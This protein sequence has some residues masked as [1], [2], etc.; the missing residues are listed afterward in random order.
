VKPVLAL[1]THNHVL[2]LALAGALTVQATSLRF[3][4]DLSLAF[5]GLSFLR[6]ER[7]ILVNLLS[8]QETAQ[9]KHSLLGLGGTKPAVQLIN[10]I[11]EGVFDFFYH[12]NFLRHI[13]VFRV[14]SK[15]QG[16][17]PCRISRCHKIQRLS[18]ALKPN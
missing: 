10:L 4:D 13:N 3:H 11:C 12:R 6:A 1:L 2:I 16:R 7:F 5:L 18:L 9:G 14:L 8:P 15:L 17:S